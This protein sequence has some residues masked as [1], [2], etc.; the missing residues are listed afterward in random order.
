MHNIVI[1]CMTPIWILPILPIWWVTLSTIIWWHFMDLKVIL[2]NIIYVF[3]IALIVVHMH[4]S[5]YVLHIK[6]ML[7]TH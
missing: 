1:T 6:V 5:W 7:S 2:E 3:G 4:A